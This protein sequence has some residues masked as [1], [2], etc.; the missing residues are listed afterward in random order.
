M[1]AT[2]N[3]SYK[4]I[5]SC[6]RLSLTVGTKNERHFILCVA[7]SQWVRTQNIT[8]SN[9]QRKRSGGRVL[10]RAL[11]SARSRPPPCRRAAA[12]GLPLFSLSSPSISSL[13]RCGT[14]PRQASEVRSGRWGPNPSRHAAPVALRLAGRGSSC[15]RW[16]EGVAVA[17]GEKQPAATLPR[18][19]ARS[20]VT[21][22][23]PVVLEKV[24][25]DLDQLLPVVGAPVR[26]A[27]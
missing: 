11:P 26:A 10:L 25:R 7:H 13:R 22:S 5:L 9:R 3:Q 24:Q 12:F 1:N 6:L 17:V 20:E 15:G 27:R 14:P 8:L 16:L 19:S 18:P 23:S 4:A 21:A 2:S